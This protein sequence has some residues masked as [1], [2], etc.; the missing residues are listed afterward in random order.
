V[1]LTGAVVDVDVVIGVDSVDIF[2]INFD[3]GL[4]AVIIIDFY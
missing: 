4:L 1:T 2:V 3:V